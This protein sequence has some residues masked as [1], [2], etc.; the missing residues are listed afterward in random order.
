M[1]TLSNIKIFNTTKVFSLLASVVLAVVAS[2]QLLRF[3][4]GWTVVVN[5]FSL[6]FWVSALASV[7][8]AVLSFMVWNEATK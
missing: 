7:I 5:G 6:P 2:I 3:V 1:K 4:L 8:A